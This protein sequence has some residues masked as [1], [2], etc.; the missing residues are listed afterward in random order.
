MVLINNF[1]R[2]SN[3]FGYIYEKIVKNLWYFFGVIY[4]VIVLRV[5]EL[6]VFTPLLDKKGFIVGQKS[7]DFGPPAHL[8]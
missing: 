8:S 7:L 1:I 5:I 2:I 4:N 3:I 6:F